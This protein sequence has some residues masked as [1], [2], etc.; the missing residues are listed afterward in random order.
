MSLIE[1]FWSQARILVE[2]FTGALASTTTSA[3]EHFTKKKVQYD[4]AFGDK[5][6]RRGARIPTT[7][8]KS[9]AEGVDRGPPALRKAA[10]STA[11][12]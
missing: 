1:V 6:R 10:F 11:S 5:S 9:F 4:F 12:H 7:K 2:F 3:A 8:A